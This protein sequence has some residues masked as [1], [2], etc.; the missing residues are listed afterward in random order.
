MYR[1]LERVLHVQMYTYF[2]HKQQIILFIKIA[3]VV[4]FKSPT[5]NDTNIITCCSYKLT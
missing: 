4:I 1:I 3:R 2:T 5:E